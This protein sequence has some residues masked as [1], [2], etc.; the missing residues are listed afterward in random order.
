MPR[1]EHFFVREIQL[2]NGQWV[3]P[4]SNA[5]TAGNPYT[6][7]R[8]DYG[9]LFRD[10]VSN[11]IGGPK[12]LTEDE[13]KIECDLKNARWNQIQEQWAENQEIMRAEEDA[14]A[15]QNGGYVRKYLNGKK[16]AFIGTVSLEDETF[17][18]RLVTKPRDPER[19]QIKL[20]PKEGN[21]FWIWDTYLKVTLN[22]LRDALKANALAE[23]ATL[24]FHELP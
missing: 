5:A 10:N 22:D 14:Y 17:R 7:N 8:R 9:Y 20:H 19:L 18:M 1:Y 13:A 12:C 15:A 24:E 11:T 23:G 2:K 21:P 3:F 6:E 16:S 4:W